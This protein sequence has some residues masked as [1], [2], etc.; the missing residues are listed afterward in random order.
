MYQNHVKYRHVCMKTMV[1]AYMYVSKPWHVYAC[2][3]LLVN[4]G[5]H[6]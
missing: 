3:H 5:S 1:S 4:H 6:W 2:M